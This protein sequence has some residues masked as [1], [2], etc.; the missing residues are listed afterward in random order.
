[1]ERKSKEID[2][3]KESFRNLGPIIP[4]IA[5]KFINT[6]TFIEKIKRAN[7]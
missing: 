7:T 3:I 4:E 1:M 2:K 6:L 5:G